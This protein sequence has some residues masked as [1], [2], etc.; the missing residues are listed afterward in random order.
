MRRIVEHITAERDRR[1]DG[2]ISDSPWRHA[3]MNWGH[4]PATWSPAPL[5][6]AAV[7]S[8]ARAAPD[9]RPGTPPPGPATSSR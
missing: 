4:D 7:A 8:V 2:D 3:L 1:P 5:P 6:A 9:P